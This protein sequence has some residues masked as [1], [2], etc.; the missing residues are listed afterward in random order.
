MMALQPWVGR[1]RK[2]E[3]HVF[4]FLQVDIAKHSSLPG[5]DERISETRN[6]FKRQVRGI[7]A[8]HGAQELA[9]AG[10]GGAYLF[11]DRE[12]DR[13]VTGALQLQASMRLFNALNT[14]NTLDAPLHIR[15]SCHK[16]EALW[17]R[18]LDNLYGK[19]VNYFLK[20]ERAIGVE[21]GVTITEDVYQQL[22]DPHLLSL[23]VRLRDHHYV[24]NGR[25]YKRSIYA[26]LSIDGIRHPRETSPKSGDVFDN[27]QDTIPV[28]DRL[29]REG[30]ADKNRTR[31]TLRVIGLG[32]QHTWDVLK[33]HI[34]GDG[35]GL[36]ENVK[37]L[38]YTIFVVMAKGRKLEAV[39]PLAKAAALRIKEIDAFKFHHAKQLAAQSIDINYGRYDHL[40]AFHGMLVNEQHLFFGHT[41]W[42]DADTFEGLKVPHFYFNKKEKPLG[43]HYVKYFES[44]WRHLEKKHGTPAVGPV[45]RRAQPRSKPL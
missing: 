26:C 16:G 29:I 21:D 43:L 25:R 40:P 30:A 18:N 27:F 1:L 14:L 12:F 45:P 4:G 5:A 15:V 28:I 32:G 22:R 10:D 35:G 6:N 9:F 8:S 17:D 36:N 41:Y 3:T 13:M 19:S 23:F 34:M 2:G 44:W 37:N 7:L 11:Q 42:T 33:R 39:R 38:D 20:S 24:V 31:T